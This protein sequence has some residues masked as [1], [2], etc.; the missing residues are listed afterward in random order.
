M[1]VEGGPP[2]EFREE[3]PGVRSRVY[4]SNKLCRRIL[5]EEAAGSDGAHKTSQFPGFYWCISCFP[6]LTSSLRRQ[7]C[8]EPQGA[9]HDFEFSSFFYESQGQ[10]P[11][12]CPEHF[13][14]DSTSSNVGSVGGGLWAR[15]QATNEKK[16]VS[17][18]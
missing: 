4:C 13:E 7:V 2:L 10:A 9:E 5:R 15:M 8:A 17:G 6:Q 11:P 3:W 1:L 16:F 14:D 18:R 12:L